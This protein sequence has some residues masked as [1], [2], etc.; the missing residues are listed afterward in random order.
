MKD[1]CRPILILACAVAK[2]R[3][4]FVIEDCAEAYCGSNY[5]GADD[6]DVSLFSFGPIKYATAFQ[7]AVMRCK[8]EG[9]L[10][11]MRKAHGQWPMQ[12]R[13]TYLF[14]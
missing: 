8:H 1:K 13:W 2:E 11:M 3:G 10:Q 12:S 5:K 7:G 4:I 9:L 6:S 14:R